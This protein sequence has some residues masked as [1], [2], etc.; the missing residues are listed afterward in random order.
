MAWVVDTAVLL[1][2]HSADPALSQAKHSADGLMLSPVTYVELA[3][4]F[5][6]HAA[7]QE[8]SSSR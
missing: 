7:L 3:P 4:A 5:A 6:G 1:D 8:H 2:I